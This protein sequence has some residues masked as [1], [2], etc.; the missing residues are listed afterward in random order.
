MPMLPARRPFSAIAAQHMNWRAILSAP[1]SPV[2]WRSPVYLDSAS[3]LGGVAAT[4]CL[5]VLDELIGD[6]EFASSLPLD[7]AS[8]VRSKQIAYI[9]G[10]LASEWCFE[11]L[12][13]TGSAEVG[14]GPSGEPIWPTGVRGSITHTRRQ[15]HVV[16]LPMANC[17]AIG[18]DSEE[19]T[20]PADDLAAVVCTEFERQ[21][22]IHEAPDPHLM[23]M[24]IFCVKEAF[25]KALHQRVGRFIDFDEIEVASLD[26]A[27]RR[28]CLRRA[29]STLLPPMVDQAVACY[30]VQA[31]PIAAIHTTVWIPRS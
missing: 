10:R 3:E 27:R 7:I 9:G 29:P 17:L 11:L 2:P 22:W 6:R 15:A 19:S 8:S 14:R 20:T 21:S 28:M 30:R 12:G 4:I 25:Y 23:T 5:E 26:P 13:I 1:A 18:I 16:V 24:L 31:G